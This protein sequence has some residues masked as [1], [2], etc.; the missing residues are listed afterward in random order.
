[1]VPSWFRFFFL[2]P[3]RLP[4]AD[5]TPLFLLLPRV[6]F[7]FSLLFILLFLPSSPAAPLLTLLTSAPI[8]PPRPA[9]TNKYAIDGYP[10]KL[11]LLLCGPPGTG[12]TSLI[13]VRNGGLFYFSPSPSFLPSLPL[14]PSHPPS[15]PPPTKALANYTRRHIVSIKLEQIQTNQQLMDLGAPP[16]LS[17]TLSLSL[18]LSLCLSFSPSLCLSSPSWL[19]SSLYPYL[20]VPASAPSSVPSSDPSSPSLAVFNT[21]YHVEGKDFPSMHSFKDVIFVMEDVGR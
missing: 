18:P 10:H 5:S 15:L 16:S 1:M 19:F 20:R 4:P 13:K 21:K 2:P 17:P 9:K 12:K 11:G 7:L 8:L 3:S 6:A 14:T